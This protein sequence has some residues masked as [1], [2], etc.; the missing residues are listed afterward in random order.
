MNVMIL[1]DYFAPG[2]R[3]G[4]CLR[5]VL[6]LVEHLKSDFQ[7]R[8]IT[9]NHD[10]GVGASYSVEEMEATRVELDCEIAYLPSGWRG[11]GELLVSVRAFKPDVVYLNSC[12]SPRMTLLPL[13]LRAWLPGRILLAPRGEL[14][15]SALASK[16]IKK[17]GFLA[18]ARGLGLYR[19]LHWHATCQAEADAIR[20]QRLGRG[21][22]HVVPDLPATGSGCGVSPLKKVPGRLRVLFLARL[23]PMKGLHR[24]LDL[25]PS[26]TGG[27]DLRIVGPEVD[28]DYVA[29]CRA[30]AEGLPARIQVSWDGALSHGEA[31]AAYGQ[32]DLYVLPTES[33]N[34]GYTIQEA[35]L[36]GCP[37]LTSTGT[38]WTSLESEGAGWTVPLEAVNLWR[39]TLQR[40]ADQ[41]EPEHMGLRRAA[42]RHGQQSLEAEAAVAATREM[43]RAV[44][45]GL[46]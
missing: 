38:P 37:V 21:V 28:S 30:R 36:A 19:N 24:L 10:L 3:G 45:G 22:V 44:S 39:E 6:H 29:R 18:L 42:R 4:G 1:S 40:V 13:A 23:H 7:L 2:F 17:K 46:D 43:L 5:A 25:L 8:I 15:P 32:A 34:H 11:C 27:I 33:E 31:M 14:L 9:R 12:F 35:L 20:E 41:D 16:G 26:I